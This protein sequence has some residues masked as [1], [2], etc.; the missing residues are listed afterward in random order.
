VDTF[1]SLPGPHIYTEAGRHRT[2]SDDVPSDVHAV[3][4]QLFEETE[5]AIRAEEYE[6]ARQTIETAT[7]VSRNK[8]PESDLRAQL[9]HGC[10]EVTAEI[11]AEDGVKYAVAVE[12]V[13]AMVER[14]P[15]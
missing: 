4:T 13:R 1:G 2:V 7:T 12:Y 8:L 3:L 10:A 9:L 15:E 11:G 14:L 6:T 5:T